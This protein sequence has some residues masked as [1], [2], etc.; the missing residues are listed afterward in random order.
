[1]SRLFANADIGLYGLLFFFTI[2]CGVVI[3]TFRP[4][5]RNEY[6]KMAKLPLEENER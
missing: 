6:D 3:W 2:F 1:M 4:G 5:A